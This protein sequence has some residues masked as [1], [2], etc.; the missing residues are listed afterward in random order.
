MSPK[1]EEALREWLEKPAKEHGLCQHVLEHYPPDMWHQACKT[2]DELVGM[3]EADGLCELLPFHETLEEFETECDS[4]TCHL[5]PKRI[6]WVKSKLGVSN[7]S[8][9]QSQT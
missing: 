3:F 2:L 1:L 6:A 5:N 8:K 9:S 7:E 4:E